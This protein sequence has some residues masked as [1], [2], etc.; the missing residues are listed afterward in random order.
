MIQISLPWFITVCVFCTGAGAVMGIIGFYF[1][2]KRLLGRQD[3]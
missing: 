2:A 1:G 3:D